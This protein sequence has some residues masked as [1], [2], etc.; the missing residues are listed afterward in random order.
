MKYQDGTHSTTD[1]AKAV[2]PEDAAWC[3]IPLTALTGVLRR[4]TLF[5]AQL[6][7]RITE[8]TGTALSVVGCRDGEAD[9]R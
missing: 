9:V 1:G 2:S 3:A 6:A 5:P 8:S 7:S 4:Q